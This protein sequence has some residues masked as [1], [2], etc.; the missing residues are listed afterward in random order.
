M[1]KLVYDFHLNVEKLNF[2]VYIALGA[3]P[4][5]RQSAGRIL[6]S[7]PASQHHQSDTGTLIG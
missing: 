1:T 3:E 4:Y 7:P 5:S 2:S 6:H